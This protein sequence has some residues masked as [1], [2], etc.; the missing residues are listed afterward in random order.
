[1]TV[2]CRGEFPNDERRDSGCLRRSSGGRRN[3]PVLSIRSSKRLTLLIVGDHAVLRR[4]RGSQVHRRNQGFQIPHLCIKSSV[5]CVDSW[6]QRY[7]PLMNVKLDLP[8]QRP[9]TKPRNYTSLL[10]TPRTGPGM[11]VGR[12]TQNSQ[13]R[14][15]MKAVLAASRIASF[16]QEV[17]TSLHHQH[18]PQP[19]RAAC[20]HRTERGPQKRRFAP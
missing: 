19:V 18:L 1:M 10:V 7:S 11:S 16:A 15:V 20:R 4:C 8:R 5:G 6:M 17:M 13:A 2:A 9:C 3:F 14:Q 12:A